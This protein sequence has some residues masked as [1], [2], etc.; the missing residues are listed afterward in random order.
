MNF[1]VVQQFKAAA[2]T[3][4]DAFR[5]EATWRSFDGLPFVGSLS[6]AAFV[7]SE[8][9]RIETNY[10]VSLDLPALARTFI[11]PERLTFV[12]ITHLD[13]GGSGTF[14]IVPDHYK[15]LL[16]SSGTSIVSGT[17]DDR[18]ERIVNGRVDVSLGWKGMFLEGPVEEAIVGGLTK[19]L[20]AQAIQLVVD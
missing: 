1:T 2:P 6:L 10:R 8:P 15:D 11:D 19:A 16:R 12:E 7:D 18:C 14:E 17:A 20:H 5:S 9:V 13:S 4:I 3:V